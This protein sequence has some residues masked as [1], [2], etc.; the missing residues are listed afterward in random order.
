MK[1]VAKK[2][3]TGNKKYPGGKSRADEKTRDK[4]SPTEQKFVDRA[5]TLAS[6]VAGMRA[7]NERR[8]KGTLGSGAACSCIYET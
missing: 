7:K 5:G 4:S 3:S 1:T 2:R 8:H 6:W